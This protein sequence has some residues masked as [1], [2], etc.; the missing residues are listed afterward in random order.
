[1]KFALIEGCRHEATPALRGECPSCGARVIAK[2]GTKK[3]WHWAHTSVRN[4]DRWWEPE[5]EWHRAWKN[6]FPASSQEVRHIAPNGELHIADVKTEA[7]F[8]LEFQHSN[9]SANERASR[10]SFYERMVWLVNGTR[11]KR[12]LPAFQSSV[13]SASVINDAPLRLLMRDR[14][15]PIVERWAGSRCPVF[16]DFGDAQ[17]DFPVI[18]DDQML[19]R[20]QYY[21]KINKV[22][23]TPVSRSSFV[24]HFR[25]DGRLRGYQLPRLRTPPTRRPSRWGFDGYIQRK[26]ARRRR[27]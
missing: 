19:W 6:E 12:D 13:R 5:T 1:M 17:F 4:C 20:L 22:L 16:V 7:G 24:D 21:E 8:V 25:N 10:E 15:S 14:E 23:A 18:P 2:C 3:I 27:F 9:I 11:L 26:A